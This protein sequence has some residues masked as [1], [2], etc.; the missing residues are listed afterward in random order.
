ML[1]VFVRK[2]AEEL[3]IQLSNG[4]M[5]PLEDLVRDY[6]R[7]LNEE[8]LKK[9]ATSE[10]R[11]DKSEKFIK[12]VSTSEPKEDKSGEFIKKVSTSEPREDKSIVSKLKVGEWFRIDR[13]V[14]DKSKEEIRCKCNKT[15]EGEKLWK[16]FEK[17]NKIADENPNQYPRLIETYIFEYN[18]EHKTQQEMRYMCKDVGD[19]MCDEVICD[20]ELQMRICNGESLDD[21]VQKADK[22]PRVRIIKL[23]NGG[24]G[25]LGGG[26]VIDNATSPA[27]L[28]KF[29]YYPNSDCGESV[30]YAFRKVATS[31]PREDKSE[32]SIKKEATSAS[33]IRQ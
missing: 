6:E 21:L 1:N 10:P 15:E 22:L 5:M 20:L 27:G 33:A 32:E 9:V 7:L 23:R 25:V 26:V 29:G 17:S 19:G 30:P 31:E 4:R 13:D 8:S 28:H 16:R 14:I 18:W 24:S 12:K 11:E 2:S 3:H